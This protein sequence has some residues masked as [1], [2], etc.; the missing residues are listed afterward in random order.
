MSDD[1]YETLGVEK[2]A[3]KTEIKKAYKKLAKKY[4]PD[5]NK[6]NPKSADKFKE[7]NEAASVLG[8]D[9]KREQYDRFG[10]AG[11]GG[12]GFNGFDFS[13]MGGFGFDFDEIFDTFFGSGQRGRRGPRRGSDL[14]YEMEITL[15]E[16]AEGIN[17]TID[18]PRLENCE[19]CNGSGAESDGDIEV[20]G[21]C[22]GR[23]SVIRQ[24]RTPFGIFQTQTTCPHCQ[25]QGKSIKNK[26][27][28]CN[29]EGRVRKTSK[30]E[31]DVPAGVFNNARLRIAG[32]GQAGP[33]GGPSGDLFIRIYMKEHEIFKRVKDDIYLDAHISFAQAVLGDE[34]KVPI[35]LGEAKMKIPSGT[36]SH[37][38]FRLK[39][40]GIPHLQS[41]GDGDQNVRV[42][43]DVPNSISKKEK[44]LLK[45][46]DKGVKKKKNLFEKIKD[47]F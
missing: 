42:I 3:S 36:Q 37:T 29:G 8:D 40:K 43:V 34:I 39:G 11:S 16:A 32:A 7:I 9:K 2:G 12:Q 6:D 41:Y 28:K 31:V 27:K 47:V 13:N 1:Y 45:E 24:Q 23:G 15:E 4:H 30:L 14:E 46:F 17:K 26:C 19:E 18:V 35:L 38:I 22:K 10:K 21:T 44:D 25:G 20:C 5:L 33:K